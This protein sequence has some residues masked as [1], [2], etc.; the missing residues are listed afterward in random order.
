MLLDASRR[1]GSFNKLRGSNVLSASTNS[2][3][4]DANHLSKGSQDADLFSGEKKNIKHDRQARAA[5]VQDCNRGCLS[6][7]GLSR[8]AAVR[9]L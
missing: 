2:R 6:H 9:R 3:A 7:G 1:C 8:S 5:S 4:Y